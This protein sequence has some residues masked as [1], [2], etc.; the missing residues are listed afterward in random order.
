VED[1]KLCPFCGAEWILLRASSEEGQVFIY[2]T[3][4]DA[5]GPTADTLSEARRCWNDSNR[6]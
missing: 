2:C 4:C 5:Q 3:D 6:D 1:L